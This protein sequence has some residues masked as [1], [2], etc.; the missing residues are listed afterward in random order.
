MEHLNDRIKERAHGTNATPDMLAKITP[1]MGHVSQLTDQLFSDLGTEYQ[2]QKHTHVSQHKDVEILVKHL[3]KK[4]VFEFQSDKLSEHA[5]I[6]LFRSGCI[7]L[8]GQTEGGHASHL[9]RHLL[10][11]RRCHGTNGGSNLEQETI[12]DHE[13]EHASDSQPIDFTIADKRNELDDILLYAKDADG[14]EGSDDELPLPTQMM[15]VY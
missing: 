6:D 14:D 12:A 7:R 11:L 1:A 2:N 10:R 9:K 8:A 13:L 5:V 3:V 15:N 4:N